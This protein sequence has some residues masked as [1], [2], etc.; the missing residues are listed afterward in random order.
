MNTIFINK[1]QVAN[2]NNKKKK[3]LFFF[4]WFFIGMNSDEKI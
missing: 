2:N 3:R 4:L 1:F